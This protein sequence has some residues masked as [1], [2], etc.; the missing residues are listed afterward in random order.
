MCSP[1]ALLADTLSQLAHTQKLSLHGVHADIVYR[2]H[3]TI[4]DHQAATSYSLQ[5][6][7][8]WVLLLPAFFATKDRFM[9]NLYLSQSLSVFWLLFLSMKKTTIARLELLRLVLCSA[10]FLFAAQSSLC[11]TFATNS[12]LFFSLLLLC[13]G[14]FSVQLKTKSNLWHNTSKE[15][16]PEKTLIFK[17]CWSCFSVCV[18]LRVYSVH[19]PAFVFHS[20]ITLFSCFFLHFLDWNMHACI[21]LSLPSVAR[22]YLFLEVLWVFACFGDFKI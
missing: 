5:I 20:P 21:F 8:L 1:F 2:N 7:V 4:T 17:L 16:Q 13:F 6:F 22:L 19:A 12:S 15:T 14:N 9:F 11:L 3:R 18:R 10:M